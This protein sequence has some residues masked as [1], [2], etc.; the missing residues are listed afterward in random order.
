MGATGTNTWLPGVVVS[1]ADVG[2][3]LVGSDVTAK[4]VAVG[5]AGDWLWQ[6]VRRNKVVKISP[7]K[8]Y[9]GRIILA[10]W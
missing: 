4:K 10:Q 2:R 9:I 7:I 1:K 3:S 6:A 8:R 5:A